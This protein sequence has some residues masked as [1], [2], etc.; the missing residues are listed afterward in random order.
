MLKSII[1]PTRTLKQN[2]LKALELLSFENVFNRASPVRIKIEATED[3]IANKQ[4]VL[5]KVLNAHLSLLE[6][7]EVVLTDPVNS[8]DHSLES[9]PVTQSEKKPPIKAAQTY[10]IGRNYTLGRNSPAYHT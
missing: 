6:N 3:D 8:R 4:T 2:K 5:R 10:N 9:K 1:Q 7:G